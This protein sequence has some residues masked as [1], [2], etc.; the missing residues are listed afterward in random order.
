MSG[1]YSSCP[2][3]GSSDAREVS[4]RDRRGAPLSTVL[5]RA[6]GHVHNDPIPS[7]AELIEFYGSRYR[8]DYKGAAKPR[9]RQI[10]RNFARVEAFWRAHADVL[11]GR[12]RMLDVGAGSGEFLFFAQGLGYE[13]RG[14]EP[15]AGYAAYCREDLGLNVAT[16]DLASLEQDSTVYDFIRLNHVLEHLRDPVDA[17]WRISAKLAPG[18]VL[19][20]EVPDVF[21]YARLKSRGGMFHYGHISNFSPWTLRAAAARAG[22]AEFPDTADAMADLTAAFFI[23]GPTMAVEDAVNPENAHRVAAALEAHQAS[24]RPP[25]AVLSRLVQKLVLRAGEMRLAS[26]LSEP[27]R[28]GEHY[29]SR[30]DRARFSPAQRDLTLSRT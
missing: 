18:G 15:N 25:L 16:A 27:A 28:I 9:G 20:V 30:L 11:T 26:S 23:P 19:Y 4:D 29:M 7:E 3:C 14:I 17:L 21:A 12:P 5:C 1:P 13:A 22:L 24:S 10:A 6:C 8:I 2:V